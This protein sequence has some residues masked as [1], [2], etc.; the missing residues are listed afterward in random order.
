M[1]NAVATSLII[2][3]CNSLIGFAGSINRA[4][5]INWK[6]LLLFTGFAVAG[7]LAGIYLSK[8]ISNEKL[9]PAFGWF[10]LITGI[11]IIA[12]ELIIK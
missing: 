1:K 12:K 10:V 8:K 3:A 9:K 11:Y 2:I 5:P 4:V 6:F 7:I